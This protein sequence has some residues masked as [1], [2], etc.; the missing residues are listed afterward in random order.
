MA[1]HIGFIN[2]AQTI[3]SFLS[4]LATAARNWVFQDRDGTIADLQDVTTSKL[5]RQTTHYTLVLTDAGAVIEMNSASANNLTVPLNSSVP[6]LYGADHATNIYIVQYGAGLTTVVA[7]GG[8]TINSSSGGLTAPSQH[9]VMLLQKVGTNEWRLTNGTAIGEW[10]NIASPSWGGFATAPVVVMRYTKVGKL[11]TLTCRTTT[12]G[13]SNATTKT[14]TL[15]YA[16]ANFFS[17]VCL[18]VINGGTS[19]TVCGSA[20]TAV[21]STTLTIYRDQVFTAWTASG[22]CQFDFQLIYESTT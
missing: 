13:V 4:N 5:N 12:T 10:V 17:C 7:T 20:Y 22:N 14:L 11:I 6:F 3:V 15:P 18:G 21:S 16:A 1:R 19:A 9:S 8:V 2:A